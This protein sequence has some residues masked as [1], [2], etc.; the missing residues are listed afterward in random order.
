MA[1]RNLLGLVINLRSLQ[2]YCLRRRWGGKGTWISHFG[3]ITRKSGKKNED[4]RRNHTSAAPKAN[5][6]KE[7]DL[8]C[9]F[10]EENLPLQSVRRKE[11]KNN[12]CGFLSAPGSSVELDLK[13][14]LY[15]SIFHICHYT[16][17]HLIAKKKLWKW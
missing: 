12:K 10:F 2:L 6:N 15:A 4:H 1:E 5:N 16:D 7:L 14:R 17:N 8:R 13:C 9:I 11:Y 3:S